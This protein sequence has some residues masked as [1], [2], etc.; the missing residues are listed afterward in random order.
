MAA[1]KR[2]KFY[3]YSN[4]NDKFVGYNKEQKT[5]ILVD[6]FSKAKCFNTKKRAFATKTI[7]NANNNIHLTVIMSNR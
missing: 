6:E 7:I 2:N 5:H 3:L 4:E 1:Q